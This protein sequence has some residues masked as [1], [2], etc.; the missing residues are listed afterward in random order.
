MILGKI[1]KQEGAL[2][3]HALLFAAVIRQAVND[4]KVARQQIVHDLDVQ[5][6]EDWLR[7]FV[8]DS[9]FEREILRPVE[10][11]DVRS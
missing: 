11:V 5:F 3:G 6:A 9:Q 10:A 2:D 4:A 8:A 7:T 1:T